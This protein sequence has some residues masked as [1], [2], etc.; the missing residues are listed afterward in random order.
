MNN[1]RNKKNYVWNELRNEIND[2]RRYIFC[3]HF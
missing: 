1:T 3:G 2:E